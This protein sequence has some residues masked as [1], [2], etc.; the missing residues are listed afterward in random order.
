MLLKVGTFDFKKIVQMR[1][2]LRIAFLCFLAT[3]GTGSSA[4]SVNGAKKTES[5]SEAG[6]NSQSFL[7]SV[8]REDAQLMGRQGTKLKDTNVIE[9]SKDIK[10][11]GAAGRYLGT[12][13]MMM[14]S[15]G[16]ATPPPPPPPPP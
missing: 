6:E 11:E 14:G 9:K 5:K 7:Q 1:V 8:P 4:A 13:K 16:N 10:R 12:K 3:T 15:D 2:S